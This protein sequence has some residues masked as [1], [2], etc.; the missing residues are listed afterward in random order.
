MKIGELKQ[1][2]IRNINKLAKQPFPAFVFGLVLV[3][4]VSKGEACA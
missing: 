4:I 3:F 2:I 1:T